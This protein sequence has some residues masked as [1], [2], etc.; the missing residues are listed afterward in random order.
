MTAGD[1]RFSRRVVL[2]G[3]VASVG[4][5]VTLADAG[6]AQA[7][8]RPRP[9]FLLALAAGTYTGA[10]RAFVIIARASDLSPDAPEPR[11]NLQ[12]NEPITVPFFGQ[13]VAYAVPGRVIR[14]RSG[15][16]VVG[17]PFARFED[18]PAGDYVVQ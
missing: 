12:D 11:D 13:D 17:Y 9:G 6:V 16:A 18:V 2:T 3:S 4:G 10:G 8:E 1:G 5:L 14:L 15:A 7:G